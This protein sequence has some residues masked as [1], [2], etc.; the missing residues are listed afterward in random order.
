MIIY[1][2][3]TVIL[4]VLLFFI[5]ILIIP[6]C[7]AGISSKAVREA[8][9]FIVKKSGKEIVEEGGE[10]LLKVKFEKLIAKYGDEVIPV[11]K[12]VGPRGINIAERHGNDAIRVMGKYGDNALIVLRRNADEV[13]PLI[14]RYGDNAIEACIKHPGVGRKLVSE[15]GKDGVRAAKKLSTAEVIKLLRMKKKIKKSGKAKEIFE[16]ITKYGGKAV[17]HIDKHKAL[18][19]V[20]A[21]GGFVITKAGLD[22]IDDPAKYFSAAAKAGRALVLGEVNNANTS[23]TERIFNNIF[24]MFFVLSIILIPILYWLFLR[25][26][27]VL[28]KQK[29]KYLQPENIEKDAINKTTTIEKE[30]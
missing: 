6:T 5:S 16:I 2:K 26:K 3:H 13:I 19:F 22:F 9:K 12:K 14:K 23:A 27:R 25:H 18:Y 28:Q 29:S 15:F 17:D 20:A 30:K 7:D 21:P 10:K 11:I 24:V 8:W 4:S 1:N